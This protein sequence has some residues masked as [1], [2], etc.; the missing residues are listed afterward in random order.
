MSKHYAFEL[1]QK[2]S[3]PLEAKIRMTKMR[4]QQWYLLYEGDVYVSF[5]GGKDSTVLLH[6][7]R[8]IYPDIPAVYC[9]T[10]LE[11]PEIRDFVKAT[12]NVTWIKPAMNFRQ[13]IQ[14]YGY[15]VISKEISDI[16]HGASTPGT[17]RWKKINGQLLTKEGE[18][19]KYNCSKWAFL[20]DAPFKISGDCCNVIKK[21]PFH[22]YEKETGFHPII[23]T[24]AEESSLR[25]TSWLQYGCNGFN[26]KRP[27]SR[28]MSF[29]TEQD[30]L[31]YLRTFNVPY[32]SVYG[33][34]VK[35]KK[36]GLTTTKCTRTGCMFCMYGCHLEPP[37]NRF[38]R[39]AET[40]P[41]VY[42]YCMKSWEEGGLGLAEVLDYIGVQH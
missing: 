14:T 26:M 22:K 33:D 41:A 23:A 20:L 40:H 38:Q 2:Q 28:P 21:R 16:I 4:I 25:T 8:Q 37:P 5:S 10:G 19:S 6:I 9:D 15:P 7:A 42:R 27:Q 34:I 36:K 32:C 30:V 13:V 31:E 29:W 35:D 11:Y 12:D 1:A 17:I 3:L 24:M 18:L 39:M